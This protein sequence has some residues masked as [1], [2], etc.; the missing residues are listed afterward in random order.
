M[1]ANEGASAESVNWVAIAQL[2]KDRSNKDCRNRWMK[3]KSQWR[4][5]AWTED[6]DRRLTQ[7]VKV[8]GSRYAKN[9]KTD[10]ATW[11]Y[12]RAASTLTSSD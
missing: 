2:Y 12:E 4:R 11:E 6:E 7:A 5:G 8:H 1:L 3:I 10:W 9:R